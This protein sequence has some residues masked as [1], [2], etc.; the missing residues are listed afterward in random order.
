MLC[1]NCSTEITFY[2][3]PRARFSLDNARHRK[4]RGLAPNAI[5]FRPFGGIS[6]HALATG[7]AVLKE[8]AASAVR[9]IGQSRWHW[10]LA[11]GFEERC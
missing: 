10:A 2:Q 11:P 7:F 5:Y 3:P 8:P 4:N 1:D 6:R 9:L